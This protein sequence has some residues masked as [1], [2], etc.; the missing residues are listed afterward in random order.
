VPDE[1]RVEVLHQDDD[2]RIKRFGGEGTG[3][4]CMWPFEWSLKE[5][6]RFCL[7]AV[8]EGD[9][10]AYAGF[11]P[12]ARGEALESTWPPSG[13]GPNAHPCRATILSSKTSAEIQR[14]W[15]KRVV[16]TSATAG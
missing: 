1:Q 14:V 12:S 8:V 11:L 4:Q 16:R 7:R 13:P 9:K 6:Y 5:T 15:R 10:T 3:G 2:V